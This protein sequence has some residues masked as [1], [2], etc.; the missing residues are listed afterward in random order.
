VTA[1]DIRNGPELR[2]CD[3][4]IHRRTRDGVFFGKTTRPL[5][6]SLRTKPTIN[7]KLHSQFYKMGKQLLHQHYRSLKPFTVHFCLHCDPTQRCNSVLMEA[8]PALSRASTG[9][10]MMAAAFVSL[11][12]PVASGQPHVSVDLIGASGM[13]SLRSSIPQPQLTIAP[14]RELW[15]GR[16][17]QDRPTPEAI[18][19]LWVQAQRRHD[20]WTPSASMT[21]PARTRVPI[22]LRCH[23]WLATSPEVLRTLNV[24][25]NL[26]VW[27]SCCL[28]RFCLSGLLTI[29][30]IT[31]FYWNS[32]SERPADDF[33]T[34]PNGFLSLYPCDVSGTPD[35][36]IL[37]DSQFLKDNCYELERSP[38]PS[39]ESG[40]D[41]ICVPIDLRHPGHWMVPCPD[42]SGGGGG[43]VVGG[44]N[45][46]MTYKIPNK[47]IR[48]GVVSSILAQNTWNLP[49]GFLDHRQYP[50]A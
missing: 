4:R 26:F 6:A 28:G 41:N 46:T 35:N 5:Y 2:S 39:C 1:V 49:D 38:H 44:P 14:L 40:D 50:A 25:L 17:R 42:H 37:N 48:H 9:L 19:P 47:G 13:W 27:A 43:Q 32:F 3:E 20:V 33:A 30:G 23:L 18:Q 10:L 15:W 29:F 24:R 21:V 12:M 45:G 16:T 31:P 34:N 36:D 8:R 7:G 22:Q 11:S